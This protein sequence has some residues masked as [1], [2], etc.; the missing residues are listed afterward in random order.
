MGAG[1][2]DEETAYDTGDLE[3]ATEE[4]LRMWVD[5]PQRAPEDVEAP[6]DPLPDAR[7]VAPTRARCQHPGQNTRASLSASA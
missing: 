7:E 2:A 1:W 6:R 5:G 3:T 4:S